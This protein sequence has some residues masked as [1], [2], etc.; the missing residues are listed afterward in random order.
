MTK[1]DLS[2]KA[3]AAA[4][5]RLLDETAE[6][7]RATSPTGRAPTGKVLEIWQL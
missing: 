4:L 5:N 7:A 3:I 2:D 6:T 1:I